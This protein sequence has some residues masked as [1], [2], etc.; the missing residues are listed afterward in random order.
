[1]ASGG[2]ANYDSCLS[3]TEVELA[4]HHYK[5]AFQEEARFTEA[6]VP[7][8]NKSGLGV[9][10]GRSQHS[11][12]P[13]TNN[14]LSTFCPSIFSVYCLCQQLFFHCLGLNLRRFTSRCLI[15]CLFRPFFFA[16]G[17]SSMLWCSIIW[18]Q[19][20]TFT[21]QRR[22]CSFS[23]SRSS[24]CKC[25]FCFPKNHIHAFRNERSTQER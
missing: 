1:M 17:V 8:D 25:V 4:W 10:S 2:R 12:A 13:T 22:S 24:A 19:P 20:D 21:C 16:S 14:T 9:I 7:W 5:Q 23:L 6:E 3:W 15:F 18:Q 11:S